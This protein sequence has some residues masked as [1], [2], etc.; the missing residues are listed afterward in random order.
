MAA[1]IAVDDAQLVVTALQSAFVHPICKD[2]SSEHWAGHAVMTL[3]FTQYSVQG[4]EAA[5]AVLRS[6]QLLQAIVFL[7]LDHGVAVRTTLTVDQAGRGLD[8][9][10]SA[11][12]LTLAFS[13]CL[14][15]IQS[16]AGK[17]AV[18]LL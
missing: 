14:Q 15:V 4:P 8:P 18:L 6:Q 10:N 3:V 5:A 11:L 1:I 12:A 17:G 16:L 9:R 7:A 13:D 2:L